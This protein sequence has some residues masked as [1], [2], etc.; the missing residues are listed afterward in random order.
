MGSARCKVEKTTEPALPVMHV[1][2]VGER[3][4]HGTASTAP[5]GGL[6]DHPPPPSPGRSQVRRGRS[7]AAR[8]LHDTGLM[9]RRTTRRPEA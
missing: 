5:V 2:G 9:V 3:I 6:S 1:T 4:C 8:S 7:R